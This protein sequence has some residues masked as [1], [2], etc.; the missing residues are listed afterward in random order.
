MLN[1]LFLFGVV[2]TASCQEARGRRVE[3]PFAL[4]DKHIT[5]T[6]THLWPWSQLMTAAAALE[7][8]NSW[9][10]PK[11][12]SDDKKFE[13]SMNVKRFK[14]EE[15][16]VRVKDRYIKV[17]GKHNMANDEVQF[18]ANHFLQ[19]FL[20]PRG[21]KQEE[22][23]AVLRETGVLT[24]SAPRHEVPPPPQ[25]IEVPIE[26]LP[27]PTTTEEPVKND[28]TTEKKEEPVVTS[29]SSPLEQLELT[30]AT[31]HIG[32]IRKKELKTIVKTAKD[33]EVTKGGDGNGLDYALMETEE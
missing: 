12:Y 7:A 16:R 17:E 30:E 1:Y 15:L 28:T 20:L 4:F 21:T 22:V 2:A 3:D 6:L 29:S 26:V 31:T 13:I 25:E 27:Q 18:L 24:I 14:P 9:D 19:R 5:H 8:E 11:I 10:T 23:T 33:N 32:K